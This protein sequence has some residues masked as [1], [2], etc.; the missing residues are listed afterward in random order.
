MKTIAFFAIAAMLWLLPRPAAIMA[1]E[2]PSQSLIA[3]SPDDVGRFMKD[4]NQR[5]KKFWKPPKGTEHKP[6]K[7]RFEVHKDGTIKHVT[8]VQTSHIRACDA[9]ALNA[10]RAAGPFKPVPE[11]FNASVSIECTLGQQTPKPQPRIHE[12]RDTAIP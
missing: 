3:Q 11:E 6:V 7:V 9:A 1:M 4:L 10:V 8:I 12:S 5:I 2:P